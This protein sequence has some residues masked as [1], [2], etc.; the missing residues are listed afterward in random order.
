MLTWW[1]F[2]SWNPI[3]FDLIAPACVLRRS[4]W[5]W[6]ARPLAGNSVCLMPFLNVCRYLLYAYLATIKHVGQL[7]VHI[8]PL[9][10]RFVLAV[11]LKILH[12]GFIFIENHITFKFMQTMV[13]FDNAV[14]GPGNTAMSIIVTVLALYLF[15]PWPR[16][17]LF[18][19]LATLSLL[20]CSSWNDCCHS[21]S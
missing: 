18:N 3:I 6:H 4:M 9:C 13:S 8:V 17:Y 12:V 15:T 21:I 1:S 16:T 10:Q 11:R 2:S 7:V 5:W 14:K 20:F 19:V